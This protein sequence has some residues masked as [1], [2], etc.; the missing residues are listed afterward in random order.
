[1]AQD[2]TA[3]S[4][5]FG[6]AKNDV[7]AVSKQAAAAFASVDAGA[8]A[9]PAA[10]NVWA[11]GFG[12][13]SHVGDAG[14]L[15]GS[16]SRSGGFTIGA[17][18]LLAPNLI[19]GMAFGFARTTS[20]STGTSSTADSYTGAL[21]ASWTPG[22]AVYDLRVA[23]GPTQIRTTRNV[24]LAPGPVQ[25]DASGFGGG[26]SFEAGYRIPVGGFIA[27]PY[28]G[29]AW[30]AFKRNAY[31][32]TQQPFGLAFPS[33]TFEKI[34][35][36]LGVAV[37]RTFVT[38]KNVTLLPEFKL[39]WAHDLRDSSLVSQAALLDQ[40]F[41]SS[42]A[43]PGRDAALVGLKLSGWT[44]SNFRLFT[45]Y[46]GEFRKNAASHQLSGG[47]RYTW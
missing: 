5:A 41:A 26:T 3:Q 8:A 13:W 25:G 30:Q 11:Q 17:D 16:R 9:P 12:R 42:A 44:Q 2:G 21:Y 10:S 45:A 36:T 14:G 40:T 43:A 4:V 29:I 1:V 28:A 18:T 31:T 47:A 24:D 19:G 38:D 34:T 6:Y 32:E 33:Q 37:S 20:S 35:T 23:A 46:N 15:S 7:S 39:G 27:K 22:A